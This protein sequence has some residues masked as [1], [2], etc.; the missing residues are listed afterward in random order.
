MVT[1]SIKKIYQEQDIELIP[2]HT[3]SQMCVEQFRHAER[4]MVV[5]GHMPISAPIIEQNL[6]T[7]QV[8]RTLLL[9]ANTFLK[10]HV[11]DSHPVLPATCAIH[12]MIQTCEA[13]L[14]GLKFQE[15][16]EFKVLKGIV[17]DHN[18]AKD[19]IVQLEP[20]PHPTKKLLGIKIYSQSAKKQAHYHYSATIA[21]TATAPQTMPAYENPDLTANDRAPQEYYSGIP[22]FHGKTFQGIRRILNS[23][24]EHVTVHCCLPEPAKSIQGQFKANY[25]NPYIADVQLQSILLWT[26]DFLKAGCLPAVVKKIEQFQAIRF[27]EDFY[28]STRI[29]SHTGYRLVTD[30]VAHDAKGRIYMRW[31]EVEL[32]ISERLKE[33]FTG[34][35]RKA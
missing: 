29:K 5:C 4:Q 18:C 9:E 27:G 14:P 17:F 20:T 25:F 2:C 12:W 34:Q 16:S 35:A 19:Y 13:L 33:Q 1:P 3:G 32:T 8:Q 22:L 11:I 21:L 26:W 15:L 6:Q 24:P 7:T 31:T 30:M 10:D 28:V 23:S